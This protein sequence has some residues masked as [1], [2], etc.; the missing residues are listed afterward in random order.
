MLW[1]EDVVK[2]EEAKEL[3]RL[4]SALKKDDPAV[5]EALGLYAAQKGDWETALK[6]YQ[7]SEKGS[8]RPTAAF[9]LRLTDALEH[10]H[11]KEEA[12]ARLEKA[13]ALPNAAPSLRARLETLRGA[14]QKVQQPPP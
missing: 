10:T 13:V 2:L 3:L 14:V 8:P 1:L 4:A 9:L 12:V 7:R 6:E 5:C 11:Q